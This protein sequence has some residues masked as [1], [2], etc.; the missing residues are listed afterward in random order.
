[1]V[2]LVVSFG[3]LVLVL[4]VMSV[5]VLF[6]KVSFLSLFTLN[7]L[8]NQGLDL[9]FNLGLHLTIKLSLGTFT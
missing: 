7:F 8:G 5:V 6:F 3:F 9:G 1:V 2:S 4:D